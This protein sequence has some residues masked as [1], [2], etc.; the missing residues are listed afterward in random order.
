MGVDAPN[1]LLCRHASR[2]GRWARLTAHAQI[3]GVLRNRR[4]P[5]YGT[6]LLAI[7][8]ILL[9]LSAGHSSMYCLTPSVHRFQVR[10]DPLQRRELNRQLLIAG[11]SSKLRIQ[12]LTSISLGSCASSTDPGSEGPWL[13]RV[14]P[15]FRFTAIVLFL[16]II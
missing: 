4:K 11:K 1:V 9:D 7:N 16:C 14:F 6:H 8:E 5:Y 10:C 3:N 15:C 2:R 12:R 13:V